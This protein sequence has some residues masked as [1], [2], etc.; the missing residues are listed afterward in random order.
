MVPSTGCMKE[1]HGH[2]LFVCLLQ[3]DQDRMEKLEN[4]SNCEIFSLEN[5]RNVQSD[6]NKW[7]VSSAVMN[8]SRF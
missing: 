8:S 6:W 7:F 2:G 4:N 3:P 5:E 1:D